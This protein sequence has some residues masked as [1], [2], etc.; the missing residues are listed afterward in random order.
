MMNT[1]NLFTINIP[2][3][4]ARKLYKSNDEDFVH[5]ARQCYTTEELENYSLDNII[6]E[7]VENS[8]VVNI[9]KDVFYS[10]F[11]LNALISA[12]AYHL[13][14]DKYWEFVHEV[15]DTDTQNPKEHWQISVIDEQYKAVHVFDYTF[16]VIY[17][18]T[19]EDCELAIK[20]LK[21]AKERI[22]KNNGNKDLLK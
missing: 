1:N 5:I 18:K 3:N 17:F 4:I 6:T 13:Y 15:V 2:L 8:K 12:V 22:V 16:G 14:G 19:K 9:Q 7:Y 10:Y 21:E 11:T 20:Y